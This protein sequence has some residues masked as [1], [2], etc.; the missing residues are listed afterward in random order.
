MKRNIIAAVKTISTLGKLIV[1]SIFMLLMLF[2]ALRPTDI[3]ESKPSNV[4]HSEA[5]DMLCYMVTAKGK[6]V[7]LMHLCK[8]SIP[9]NLP[10]SSQSPMFGGYP[11]ISRGPQSYSNYS[12]AVAYPTPPN[13][14]DYQAMNNFDRQLYDN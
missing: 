14:Y 12:G 6:V 13:V 3:A 2:A 5:S 10:S 4:S 11:K 9:D 7:D 1:F 8:Q